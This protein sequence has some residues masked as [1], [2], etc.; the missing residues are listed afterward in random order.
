MSVSL[1]VYKGKLFDC[2]TS[3][4]ITEIPVSFQSVWNDIWEKAISECNIKKFVACGMFYVNEIPTV[5]AELDTIYDWVHY[6]GGIKTNY[7]QNRIQ[8]LKK[9]FNDF[10]IENKNLDYWFDLG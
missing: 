10:Y 5:L 8:E 6:N 1:L 7:I 9:Y 3:E 2:Y 4:C